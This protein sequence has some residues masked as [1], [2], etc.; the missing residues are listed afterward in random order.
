[1]PIQQSESLVLKQSLY[2]SLMMFII[3]LYPLVAN[4]QTSSTIRIKFAKG[5]QC[6]YYTGKIVGKKTFILT[7]VPYDEQLLYVYSTKGKKLSN[8]TVQGS[9]GLIR[10]YNAKNFGI[11]ETATAYPIN[12]K[13]D[14]SI[15]LSSQT[16]SNTIA[17]CVIDNP[18]GEKP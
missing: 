17:F 11:T 6:G 10:G 9:I 4:A 15:S 7:I 5:N 12:Q 1:M 8:L 18:N 2:F 14:Y 16:S 13:G 3:S